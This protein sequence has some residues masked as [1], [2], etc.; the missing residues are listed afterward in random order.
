MP[1]DARCYSPGYAAGCAC[2]V[3]RTASRQM[4]MARRKGAI[5]VL[6]P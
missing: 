2:A 3:L 6:T 4:S 1:Q 5:A